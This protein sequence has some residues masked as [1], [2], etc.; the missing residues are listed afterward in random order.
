MPIAWR[1]GVRSCTQHPIRNFIS[2]GKLSPSFRAFTTSIT[3]IQV[4]WNIQEAFECPNWK[5]NVNKE[6]QVLKKNG[7]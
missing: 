2:Y 4:P 5:A 1:K 7:T 3:E 6:I